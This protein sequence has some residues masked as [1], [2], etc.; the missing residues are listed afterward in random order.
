MKNAIIENGQPVEYTA[1]FHRDAEG[2]QTPLRGRSADF[3]RALNPPVYEVQRDLSVP[4]GHQMTGTELVYD[5]E[6]D[7]V[8]ERAVYEPLS[9]DP[10]ARQIKAECKRRILAVASAEAQ[11]NIGQAGVIYNALRLNGV[12]DAD[13]LA[14]AGFIEV[15]LTIA[16]AFRGWVSA[17]SDAATALIGTGDTGYQEDDKWPPVPAGVADLAARF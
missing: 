11:S 17:M 10:L 7:T 9:G 13:A 1:R 8:F 3:K 2:N 4:T 6:A 12:P 16:A 14:Q 15:D 5:A